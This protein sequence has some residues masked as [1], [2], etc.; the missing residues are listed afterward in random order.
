MSKFLF[1]EFDSVSAKQWKQK[2]QVD[3]K[4]ADYNDTL[5]WQSLEGIHVKPFYH[6]EEL[7]SIL[8]PIPGQPE[9][10]FVGQHIFIDKSAVAHKLASD[11]LGRGAEALYFAADKK[12]NFEVICDELPLD[13]I[14]LYFTLNFLDQDFVNRLMTYCT[15]K[16]I[17]VFLDIDILGHLA[18]TGNWFYDR[19]QDHEI[20]EGLFTQFTSSNIMSVDST[21]YQ[22]AG[23]NIVQ[24]LAYALAHANEYLNHLKDHKNAKELSI[25]FKVAIGSNYF[26]EISK[27]RA[28]RELYASL[29]SAYGMEETCH[30]IA[31]PSK[32]NKTLYDYNL[33]MLRTTTESMSAAMGGANTICNMPYDALYHK[34]N[35]FGERISRNQLLIL[36]AESYLDV[37]SNPADGS[38]YIENITQQ[39][40]EKALE[41]F[42]ELERNGGFHKQLVAGSIQ[43]KIKESAQKEQALFNDGKLILVGTN[44]YANEDDRMKDDLELYPF[45]KISPRKTT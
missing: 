17:T 2:I 39:L 12:F 11:V 28:L 3:L 10:W 44:K 19:K 45:M 21:L 43:R 7:P 36:K 30:V 18:R 13:G 5:V 8:H 20:L 34:S 24:Q 29:A 23:A 4:G 31:V 32:R 25:T 37:V 1:E 41:L 40:A 42:K 15:T 16:K 9:K 27:I 33:N 38:Y 6:Q 22:N 35:E 14:T 26:F